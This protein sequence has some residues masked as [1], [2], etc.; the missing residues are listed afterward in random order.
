MGWAWSFWP[1]K[2]LKKISCEKHMAKKH[3]ATVDVAEL[4]KWATVKDGNLFRNGRA[5]SHRGRLRLTWAVMSKQG[6]KGEPQ[7]G[8]GE[9]QEGEFEDQGGEFDDQEGEEEKDKDKDQEELGDR[10]QDHFDANKIL[11]KEVGGD[12]SDAGMDAPMS[13][14][15]PPKKGKRNCAAAAAAP[16]K[17]VKVEPAAAPAA[18][19]TPRGRKSTFTEN[20]TTWIADQCSEFFGGVRTDRAPPLWFLRDNV[21]KKGLKAGVFVAAVDTDKKDDFFKFVERVR[22]VARAW[23][24]FATQKPLDVEEAKEVASPMSIDLGQSSPSLTP[25]A[26]VVLRSS[27]ARK[28]R[29]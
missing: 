1:S 11:V 22:H 21:A 17:K 5:E 20:E 26:K 27:A 6:D 2:V 7:V 13:A 15:G 24:V 25:L 18:D 9:D 14:G 4:T 28:A 8:E 10:Q 3:T 16:P 29:E 19:P 12:E 23:P